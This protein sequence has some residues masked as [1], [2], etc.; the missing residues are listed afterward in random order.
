MFNLASPP[1]GFVNSPFPFYDDLLRDSPV[2]PQPDGSFLIC[3]H[4]DLSAIYKDTTLYIS[5]KK[6]AFAPKFGPGYV[7]KQET[8]QL[9]EAFRLLTTREVRGVQIH[10]RHDG[11]TWCDTIMP[12]PDG[13]FR[14]VRMEQDFR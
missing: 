14:I 7:G 12:I 11:K 13:R 8:L 10:Y 5:D 3:K 6:Q 9:D 4:A 1:A 2:T